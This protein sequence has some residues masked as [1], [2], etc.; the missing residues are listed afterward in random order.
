MLCA[1]TLLAQ[2]GFWLLATHLQSRF[3]LPAAVPL[4]VACAA[5]AR[6]VPRVIAPKAFTAAGLA[7]SLVPLWI[8]HDFG[9]R[10]LDETGRATSD[11]SLAIGHRDF[12]TG[13][14]LTVDP[15]SLG[16]D[17]ERQALAT[18]RRQSLVY[19]LNFEL[20]KDDMLVLVGDATPFWYRRLL[21]Y[22]TVFDRG[23][24]DQV[25]MA[26]PEHP[27]AWG[28]A[29]ADAGVRF[30]VINESMLKRWHQSGWLNPAITAER[31]GRF[32][33]SAGRLVVVA[34]GVALVDLRPPPPSTPTPTPPPSGG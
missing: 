9:H 4:A 8:Y 25:A 32:A 12:M 2:I 27:E 28:R 24:L 10:S 6:R 15:A 20:P 34:P 7:W 23:I 30:V 17:A 29:L 18:A 16:S 13:E 5:L 14:F 31:L 22:S 1:V 21:P 26:D 3:L 19:L 33:K 11:S